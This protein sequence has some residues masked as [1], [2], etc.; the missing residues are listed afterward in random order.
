MASLVEIDR[1]HDAVKRLR[2]E[3]IRMEKLS[4]KARTAP[5]CSKAGDKAAADL[6]WQAFEVRKLEAEVHARAVDCG[7]ADLRSAGHYE[8]SVVDLT[9]WHSYKFT[10]EKP[11]ALRDGE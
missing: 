5:L 3:A 11:A 2:K 4:E 7:F 10:P 8:P 1:L 9:G 6:N